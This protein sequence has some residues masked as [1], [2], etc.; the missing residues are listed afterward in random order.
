MCRCDHISIIILPQKQT[1]LYKHTRYVLHRPAN[2]I[3]SWGKGVQAGVMTTSDSALDLFLFVFL[4]AFS[5][6]AVRLA[7]FSF[8]ALGALEV[9]FAASNTF[10]TSFCA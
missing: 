1:E 9:V 3:V 6:P 5:L 2:G 4:V 10:S 7:L 8:E